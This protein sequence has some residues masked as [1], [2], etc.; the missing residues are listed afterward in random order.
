MA[1]TPWARRVRGHRAPYG[2]RPATLW[3]SILP[4]ECLRLPVEL[5]RVDRLLDDPVFF[6]PFVPHVDPRVGRASIPMET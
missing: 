4:E 1:S 2:K 6:A 5:E 3:E